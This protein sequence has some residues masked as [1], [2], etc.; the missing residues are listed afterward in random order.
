MIKRIEFIKRAKELGFSL[1]EIYELLSLRL[2]PTTPCSEIKSRAEAK[3]VYI[4]EKIKTLKG[5]KKALV[6]LSRACSGRGPISEC[7]I[8]E[9]LEE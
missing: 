7:P 3:I 8:L 1:R 6:E 2:D 4:E 9:S 5:M